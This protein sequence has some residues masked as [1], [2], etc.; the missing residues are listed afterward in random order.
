MAP[1]RRTN[2]ERSRGTRRALVSAARDRFETDGYAAASL[3]AIAEAAGVTKGALYHHFP[4]KQAL[5]DAVVV[6]LQEELA[7]HVERTGQ[8]A[9]TAWD[10]FVQAWLSYIQLT[11]EPGIRRLMLEAPVVLGYP[12]WQ[13]ID[14]NHNL[15]AIT[16][17]LER[18]QAK[19]ELVFTASADLAR[20]LLAVSNALG[21]LVFQHP[22]PTAMRAV[23][24]PVWEH[25][26]RSLKKPDQP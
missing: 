23:V 13:E 24:G 22:D 8:H 7:A 18:L 10:K 16:A 25:F 3:D 11:P 21:T 26:L 1:V 14:E 6:D 5:Y 15:A 19:D 17:S 2:E 9:K 20:V 4:T 12:R